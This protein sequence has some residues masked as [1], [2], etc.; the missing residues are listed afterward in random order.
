MAEGRGTLVKDERARVEMAGQSTQEGLE[1]AQRN[2]EIGDLGILG[3]GRS[4]DLTLH[5]MG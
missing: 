3:T 5:S 1:I 2:L 4:P